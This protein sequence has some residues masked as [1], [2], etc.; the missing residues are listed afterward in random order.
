MKHVLKIWV[1][2]A[3]VALA[4]SSCSNFLEQRSQNMAYLENVEDLDELLLGECYL[5]KGESKT[6]YLANNV[7]NWAGILAN[8]SG[9]FPAI[10][11]LDD[12]VAEYLYNPHTE[13]NYSRLRLS[14]MHYWQRDPWRDS[15]Y[16]EITDNNWGDTYRRIAV[17]NTILDEVDQFRVSDIQRDST[18]NRI[19]GEAL[20][21]R[22]QYYFWL[23]NLYG[24]PYRK[25]FATT[26][27]CIPLKTSEE[28]GGS[29][30]FF[31]LLLLKYFNM[32]K[33]FWHD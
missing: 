33:K 16:N 6:S 9:L 10:H 11:V 25:T 15:E 26:D 1:L 5:P 14:Q 4:L 30:R 24:Q 31:C 2:A 17:L 12:D 21:L 18:C 32:D 27:L 28:V 20:F 8:G 19:E 23:A 22:A 3:G 13:L 7:N 29:P